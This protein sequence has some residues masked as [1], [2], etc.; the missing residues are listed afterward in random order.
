MTPLVAATTLVA[1]FLGVYIGYGEAGV[2]GAIFYGA[3]I[4]PGGTLL[5]S[6]LVR[7]AALLRGSWK[8]LSA[9]AAVVMLVI[10]TWSVYL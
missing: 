1:L 5:G 8:I 6:L 3:L 2:G 9:V 7:T 10:L 4:G